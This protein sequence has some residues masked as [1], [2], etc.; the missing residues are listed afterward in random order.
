MTKR[1]ALTRFIEK[2]RIRHGNKYD[3]SCVN[4]INNSSP[5]DIICPEHGKFKQ[6]PVKHT[7]QTGCPKCGIVSLTHT[8]QQFIEKAREKHGCKYD[9]GLVNYSNSYTR[10]T[11]ICKEHGS[12]MQL[13]SKHLEGNGCPKCSST[14]LTTEE[15]ITRAVAIHGLYYDYS[16]VDYK[17]SNT[18]VRIICPTH[19]EFMQSP[20][21]HINRKSGC[22]KCTSTIS[23]VETEWLDH[24]NIRPEYRQFRIVVNDKLYRVDGYNPNTNTVYEFWGDYWH[25][26][27]SKYDNFDIHPVIKKPYGELYNDT[28]VKKDAIISAGYNLIDVWESDWNT[29]N[30]CSAQTL[31]F[32]NQQRNTMATITPILDRIVVKRDEE[33]SK[34]TGGI[35]LSGSSIEKP[36]Q[37]TVLAVG[38]GRYNEKGEVQP[39]HLNEG[40]KILFGKF[41]GTEVTVEAET[42]LI[43]REEDILGILTK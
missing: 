22:R 25:G 42:F 26:N 15:F 7:T 27:P 20:S 36:S 41:A 24:H 1:A 40:D 3:Y 32:N 23:K 13:P 37:G 29:R 33:E 17:N 28:M 16:L 10:I 6:R 14:T 38:P 19:G 39:M 34:S 9:Y 11:I 18:G 5:V 12:F 2:A 35:I 8:T 4:Y 43:M 31:I 30:V 21:R